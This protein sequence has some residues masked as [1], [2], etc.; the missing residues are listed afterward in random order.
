MSVLGE[1]E[2]FCLTAQISI[3]IVPEYMTVVHRM[4]L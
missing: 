1:S 2:G 4:P 3:D